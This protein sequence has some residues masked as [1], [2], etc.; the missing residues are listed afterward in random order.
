MTRHHPAKSDHRGQIDQDQKSFGGRRS[1]KDHQS[2][3]IEASGIAKIRESASASKDPEKVQ[4]LEIKIQKNPHPAIR[5][6]RSSHQ[7][8]KA[9]ASASQ[10]RVR[11][12]HQ[13]SGSVQNYQLSD[14][15]IKP[16]KEEYRK[17]LSR[18]RQVRAR[19]VSSKSRASLKDRGQSEL[20][21][22]SKEIDRSK[23]SRRSASSSSDRS[24]R[25][26][27]DLLKLDEEIHHELRIEKSQIKI[28]ERSSRI[29]KALKVD[30]FIGSKRG[31]RMDN[32]GKWCQRD[33]KDR[34]KSQVWI[35]NRSKQTR[36]NTS[37]MSIKISGIKDQ[38][39]VSKSSD[40]SRD[41]ISS[42]KKSNRDQRSDS[43]HRNLSE[44]AS[45]SQFEN[46]R[47][48]LENSRKMSWNI[49]MDIQKSS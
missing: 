9:S 22:P 32:T 39:K 46:H 5:N 34:Q 23:K 10:N 19:R 14:S 49:G 26:G 20:F 29:V 4:K 7:R 3:K 35:Q 6:R 36:E 8:S 45:K 31:S 48:R 24:I 33:R 11:S 41:Q 17:D 30:N 18:I 44:I 47:S 27:R 1:I 38:I 21:R 12:D 13:K 37:E 40:Q 43:D 2:S 16:S 42:T 25:N 28:S 15:R